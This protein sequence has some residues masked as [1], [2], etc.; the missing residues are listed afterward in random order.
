MKKLLTLFIILTTIRIAHCQSKGEVWQDTTCK[1]TIEPGIGT[2]LYSLLGS[3]DIRFTNLIQYNLANSIT[4]VSH[5]ALA[6]DFPNSR[7][8]DVEQNHSFTIL[9]KLG[10]GTAIISKGASH[11]FLVLGGLKYNSYSGTLVN[12]HPIEKFT[13]K[14]SAFSPDYG[15]MYNLKKGKGK[16]FFSGRLYLPLNDGIFNMLETANIEIGVGFQLPG[17]LLKK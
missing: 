3:R 1:L 2:K 14:T 12:N 9:Q 7:I 13:S 5:S 8:T 16:K 4:L 15:I 11:N 10:I 6:F 17:V